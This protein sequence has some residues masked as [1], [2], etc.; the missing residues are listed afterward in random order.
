M[1]IEV[2]FSVAVVFPG[3]MSAQYLKRNESVVHI[4]YC[5][6]YLSYQI[7]YNKKKIL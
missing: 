6:Y 7:K 5:H 2:Y 1:D 4:I 3:A